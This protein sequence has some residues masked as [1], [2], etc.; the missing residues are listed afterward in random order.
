MRR[1]WVPSLVLGAC[2]AV[3]APAAA[4]SV[5]GKLNARHKGY[6]EFQQYCA[7][8]HGIL[9][10]GNGLLAPLLTVHPANLRKLGQRYGMPLP[11][12]QLMGFIDGRRPVPAHGSREMPVWGKRL[13]EYL[14]SPTPEARKRG[15]IF[16]ILDYI[17]SI[18]DP[19]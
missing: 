1:P 6:A 3:A 5:S 10:D 4:Q 17:D 7:S 2:L 18:Q 9:G 15:A 11:K 14:P 19:V 8:C 16:V 13:Y 12:Q